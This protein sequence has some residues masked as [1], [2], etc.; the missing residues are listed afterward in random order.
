ME[1]T[2][3]EILKTA[4]ELEDT[5]WEENEVLEREARNTRRKAQMP[6][7]VTV[8]RLGMRMPSPEGSKAGS[9]V[10]LVFA[11]NSQGGQGCQVKRFT[12]VLGI[13]RVHL[14]VG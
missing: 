11:N 14:V 4:I 12:D 9:Y 6:I 8:A 2:L 10:P 7:P 3:I 1:S 13:K 5:A